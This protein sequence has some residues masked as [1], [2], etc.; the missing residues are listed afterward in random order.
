[1]N[2]AV[3]APLKEQENELFSLADFDSW[4]AAQQRRIFRLC[5]RLLRNSDDADSAAQDAFVKAYRVLQR[6][7][8]AQAI[9]DADRWITRIAI[10]TCLD[11]LRSRKW[12]FWRQRVAADDEASILLFAPALGPT[13]EEKLLARDLSRR[14]NAALDTLSARQR[15]VFLLRHE[16]DMTLEE[17]SEI[18]GVDV[19]TVKA[20]M[21]RAV[22]KLRQELRDL[23]AKPTLARG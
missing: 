10:N 2:D 3:A 11:R 20:H 23:Y 22:K 16:E 21:S 7:D 14:L 5:W 15:S 13:P 17:I 12:M 8:G 9:G 1:M 19:G 6:K 18:L 4:V